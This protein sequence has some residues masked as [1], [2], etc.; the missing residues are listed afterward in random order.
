MKSTARKILNCLLATFLLTTALPAQAQQAKKLPRIGVL[1][2]NPPQS[3]AT[4]LEAFRQ[5]LRDLGYLEGQ[6][7]VIESRSADGKVERMPELVTEL[8]RLKVDVIVTGGPAAT[9]P[10]KEATSTIPIVMGFD[11]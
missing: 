3:I 6:N 9:R 11:S 10:T 1:T 7:I 8:V 2:V 4:R 5:G